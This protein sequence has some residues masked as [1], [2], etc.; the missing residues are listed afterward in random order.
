MSIKEQPT[1]PRTPASNG[2]RT[3]GSDVASFDQDGADLSK[4][5]MR[6]EMKLL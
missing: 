6:T 4:K 1:D 2:E 3:V 5:Q